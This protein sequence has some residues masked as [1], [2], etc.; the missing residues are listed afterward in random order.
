[1]PTRRK[2]GG[3]HQSRIDHPVAVQ[4]GSVASEGVPPSAQPTII[5][6]Q[7]SDKE[8]RREEEFEKQLGFQTT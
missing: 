8:S 4:Y 6:M 2:Q 7:Q 3:E 1:M 5:G